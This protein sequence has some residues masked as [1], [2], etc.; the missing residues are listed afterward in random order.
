MTL[1]RLTRAL[2][3]LLPGRRPLTRHSEPRISR[4]PFAV[5]H[6]DDATIAEGDAT[7]VMRNSPYPLWTD[8]RRRLVE[9]DIDPATA[10]VADSHGLDPVGVEVGIV[11]SPDGHVIQYRYSTGFDEWSD[12][13]DTWRADA[14]HAEHVEAAFKKLRGPGGEPD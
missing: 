3:K 14:A 5:A 4:A 10:V 2:R 1:E 11:V 6:T 13:T 8:L 9:N 7:W 12:M